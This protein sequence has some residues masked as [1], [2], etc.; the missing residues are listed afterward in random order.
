MKPAHTALSGEHP[1]RDIER[2]SFALCIYQRRLHRVNVA[3]FSKLLVAIKLCHVTQGLCAAM[4]EL[5][6]F[7][8]SSLRSASI[9]GFTA[10]SSKPC[11]L[12]A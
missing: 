6:F 12:F 11:D 7:S 5:G 3:D 8:S 10:C 1:V 4:V 9:V 2:I